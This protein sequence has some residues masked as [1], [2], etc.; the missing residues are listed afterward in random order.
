MYGQ[1]GVV[2]VRSNR[3]H[4]ISFEIVKAGTDTPI[5][6]AEIPITLYDLDGAKGCAMRE[7][8]YTSGY[9]YGKIGSHLASVTGGF[10]NTFGP[11]MGLEA[12]VE[13]PESPETL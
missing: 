10:R 5:R 9:I 2:S 6:L 12:S 11:E 7:S 3:A 1:L 4:P 13:S 8:V